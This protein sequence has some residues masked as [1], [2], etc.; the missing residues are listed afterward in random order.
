MKGVKKMAKKTMQ[1]QITYKISEK[2][3]Y[4]DIMER[5]SPTAFYKDLHKEYLKSQKQNTVTNKDEDFG[6]IN[7]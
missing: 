2:Y 4:D 7:F 5:S 3:L 1:V 6:I